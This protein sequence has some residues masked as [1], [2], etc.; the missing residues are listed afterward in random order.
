VCQIGLFAKVPFECL[1]HVSTQQPF[2]GVVTVWKFEQATT[3]I[4]VC[5]P[6]SVPKTTALRICLWY[7]D[8]LCISG[9][10]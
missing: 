8:K 2:K 4:R 10:D 1:P 9:V 6:S 7:Q 3:K 5:S